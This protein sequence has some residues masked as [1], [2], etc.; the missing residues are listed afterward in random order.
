MSRADQTVVPF[1]K[2]KGQPLEAMAADTQYLDWLTA[3]PWFRERY[4]NLYT[5][6]V[7]NFGEPSE[8]PEHNELQAMFLDDAFCLRFLERYSPGWALKQLAEYWQEAVKEVRR[9]ERPC[10]WK[11]SCEADCDWCYSYAWTENLLFDGKTFA[12]FPIVGKVTDRQFEYNGRMCRSA[13][14]FLVGSAKGE[15]IRQCA[16]I[17]VAIELKPSIG[18][19][20]PAVLRQMRASGTTCLV[21]RYYTGIGATREQFIAIFQSAGRSVVFLDELLS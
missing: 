15:A 7:N 12:V 21:T 11:R 1:G 2:Y 13:D 9:A 18:D 6:V 16:E 10:V 17:E 4:A 20:Y 8:T 3:Q 5:L 19:D 14:V